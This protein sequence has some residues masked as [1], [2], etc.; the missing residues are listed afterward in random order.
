[1][2]AVADDRP[3]AAYRAETPW[4]PSAAIAVAVLASLAPMAVALLA[5]LAEDA[6]LVTGDARTTPG[7]IPSLASP[8]MLAQMIAGQFLSLAIVWVAAGWKGARIPT[9]RLAPPQTGWLT[10]VGY[11]ALLIVLIGPIEILLYRLAE[12][13][14]FS[15]GRWILDGLKSPYWWAVI[16]AAVV[17]APL[18]E[19]ITFRGFLLSALAKSRLGYWPAAILS[20]GLWTVLHVGYSGPGLA[21]VFLA[22]VGMSWIMWRTGSM[23]AVVVAHA[24]INAFALTVIFL[25]APTN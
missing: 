5:I 9:L 12:V 16:L 25:F 7:G 18:W 23:R 4:G 6:S 22:G 15:D 24:V 11:G 13:P 20:S 3:R 19:E 17:L 8:F 1:M 2:P 14:L 21:S 10:A